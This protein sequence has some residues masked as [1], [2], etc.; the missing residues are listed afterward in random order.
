MCENVSA[1]STS[2]PTD[3]RD[4]VTVIHKG[5]DS[6]SVCVCCV[7]VGLDCDAQSSPIIIIQNAKYVF[8]E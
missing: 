2:S 1:I 4:G 8:E 6:F 5:S 3:V 7:F